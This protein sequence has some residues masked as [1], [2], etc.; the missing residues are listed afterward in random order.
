M[1]TSFV[2]FLQELSSNWIKESLFQATL[3]PTKNV[4]AQQDCGYF[5]HCNTTCGSVETK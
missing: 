5:L 4:A 1:K 3:L 2:I